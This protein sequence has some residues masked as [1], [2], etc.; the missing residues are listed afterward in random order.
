MGMALLSDFF[1]SFGVIQSL[2]PPHSLPTAG[3]VCHL[4]LD[5]DRA[6]RASGKRMVY[7]SVS[8][9]FLMAPTLSSILFC[10]HR[11]GAARDR[12]DMLAQ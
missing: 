3:T 12:N 4:R 7:A 1:L 8:R 11:V 5:K 9:F 6:K 2:Y 10:C